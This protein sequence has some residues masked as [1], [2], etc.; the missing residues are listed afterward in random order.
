MESG[1]RPHPKNVK[2]VLRSTAVRL[3]KVYCED[4]RD[5]LKQSVLLPLSQVRMSRNLGTPGISD[6]D[7]CFS[8]GR[9]GYRRRIQRPSGQ[10]TR[11]IDTPLTQTIY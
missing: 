5:A 8:K 4:M 6:P 9:F 2:S 3:S 1:K 7:L 11:L 10:Q